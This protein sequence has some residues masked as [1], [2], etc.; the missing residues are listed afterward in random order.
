MLLVRCRFELPENRVPVEAVFRGAG[1]LGDIALMGVNLVRAALDVV[2]EAV[3]GVLPRRRAAFSGVSAGIDSFVSACGD[4][5]SATDLP[6]RPD[7]PSL[8]KRAPWPFRADFTLDRLR[9]SCSGDGRVRILA[10]RAD[11]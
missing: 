2:V 10:M 11:D 4:V 9:L 3:V 1:D 6:S 7:K 5:L 8:L